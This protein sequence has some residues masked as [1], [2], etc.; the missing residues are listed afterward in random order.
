MKGLEPVWTNLQSLDLVI[1][2]EKCLQNAFW[3]STICYE[4]NFF[5]FSRRVCQKFIAF[6]TLLKIYHIWYHISN[7]V[8]KPS[9]NNFVLVDSIHWIVFH[10]SCMLGKAI[11]A[12]N[13]KVNFSLEKICTDPFLLKGKT[14]VNCTV[15]FNLLAKIHPCLFIGLDS[16]TL[17]C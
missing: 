8:L 4:L 15:Q 11:P 12:T 10:N 1:M 3:K 13:Y 16:C 7:L 14:E 17:D 9:V 6:W 5:I 2:V